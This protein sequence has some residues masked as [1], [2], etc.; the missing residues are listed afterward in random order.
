VLRGGNRDGGVLGV[1]D[2][3]CGQWDS[4]AAAAMG[5]QGYDD[6]NS[7]TPCLM[8]EMT[9]CGPWKEGETYAVGS[10]GSIS[11]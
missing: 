10:E 4:R 2:L 7:G 11:F 8:R 5:L 3:A 1:P 9:M 6:G